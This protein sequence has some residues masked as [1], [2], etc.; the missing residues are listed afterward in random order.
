MFLGTHLLGLELFFKVAP[1]LLF[2]FLPINCL[3][4][5]SFPIELAYYSLGLQYEVVSSRKVVWRPPHVPWSSLIT[6][7]V[8]LDQLPA[9]I[10]FQP[11][12][13]DFLDFCDDFLE[14]RNHLFFY[15]SFSHCIL[16]HCTRA[17]NQ[18]CSCSNWN[19]VYKW[20]AK[21]VRGKSVK[22]KLTY[23]VFADLVYSLCGLRG[24]LNTSLIMKIL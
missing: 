9:R 5:V 15:C 8:A 17:V 23:V 3:M 19:L 7:I 18:V 24:I 4:K 10:I 20:L 1:C 12:I 13:S 22:S 11:D 2:G 21:E 6:W 16:Q 14:S